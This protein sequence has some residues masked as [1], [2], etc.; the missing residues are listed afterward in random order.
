MPS[1]QIATTFL[2]QPCGWGSTRGVNPEMQLRLHAAEEAIRATFDALPP[3]RRIDPSTGRGDAAFAE[4]SGVGGPHVCW[5]PDAG[6]HSAGAAIDIDPAANPYIVTRNHGVPGGE[7]GGDELIEMRR[8]ALAAYDRAMH[9][10]SP[11]AG[12][13]DLGARKPHEAT[14]SVWRRFKALSDALASYLSFAIDPGISDVRRIAI[15][16]ADDVSDDELLA[17]IGEDERLPLE[18]AAARLGAHLGSAEFRAA[19][20]AWPADA[21]EQYL[22]ILRDYEHARI[23]LVVGAPS[24]TP[25]RTRN[26]ARGLLHLRSEIVTALCDQG[27]RWGACDFGIRADGSSENGALMHFDLADNGGYPEINSLLRFG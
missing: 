14:E 2:G 15:E 23:P 25:S 7:P 21:R 24:A 26:P 8:R 19:H 9:F 1:F 10:V 16:N 20:P 6:H 11:A 3:E 4:W 12:A 22:R 13:A 18:D 27:L 17:T 5:L